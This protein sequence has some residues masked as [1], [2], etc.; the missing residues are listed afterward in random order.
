M[1]RRGRF[2]LQDADVLSRLEPFVSVIGNSLYS[3]NGAVVSAGLKAATQMAK[4]PLKS[5]EKSL[6]VFVRQAIEVVRRGGST[7][8]ELSQAALKT[9]T[10]I[11]RDSPSMQLKEKD[12]GFLIEVISPDLEDAERQPVAFPLLRAIVSRKF[13]V[14]EIYDLMDRIREIMITSQSLHV[15]EQCRSIFLQF[16]L[17][18]PRGKGRLKQQIT[19][20]SRNLSYITIVVGCP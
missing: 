15:Q 13:V 17:E 19:F 14:P 11:I 5:L 4:C 10:A 1:Y 18:Y 7:E 8:S 2:S 16:L 9:L 6:P 20:P 12:L 3:T